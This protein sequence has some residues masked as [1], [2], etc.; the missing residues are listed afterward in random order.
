MRKQYEQLLAK[1]LESVTLPTHGTQTATAEQIADTTLA[2]VEKMKEYANTQSNLFGK[3]TTLFAAAETFGTDLANYMTAEIA[4]NPTLKKLAKANLPTVSTDI[5]NKLDDAGFPEPFVRAAQGIVYQCNGLEGREAKRTRE[6]E[7]SAP[8][9]DQ[10]MTAEALTQ[11][12]EV[13]RPPLLAAATTDTPNVAN[14]I[15]SSAQSASRSR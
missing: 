8:V 3:S 14:L 11:A 9:Q 2:L 5:P 7:K 1:T 6:A 15:N 13:A 10:P 4:E 12:T